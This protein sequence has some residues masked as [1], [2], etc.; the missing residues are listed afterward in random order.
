MTAEE[1]V[2]A[3][4]AGK[5]KDPATNLDLE[6]GENVKRAP[7]ECVGHDSSPDY[8]TLL[9]VLAS[10]YKPTKRRIAA[11]PS[12]PRAQGLRARRAVCD[13]HDQVLRRLRAKP[14][15]LL[16]CRRRINLSFVASAEVL[17]HTA[18]LHRTWTPPRR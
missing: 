4:K 8:R 3:V 18:F 9:E 12:P 15:F 5:P 14:R 16:R 11:P 7:L 13:A 17:H 6:G 10:A 1:Y 2:Q